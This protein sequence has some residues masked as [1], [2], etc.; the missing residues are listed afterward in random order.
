MILLR[1]LADI[2]LYLTFGLLVYLFF[3]ND[4]TAL[5][6]A[7]GSGIISALLFIYTANI[8]RSRRHRH[9]NPSSIWDWF[10]FID[11]IEIP[12]RLLW[13]LFSNIWR[14]FD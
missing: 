13:W 5:W 4:I 1:L 14:I 12:L 9:S 7:I 6:I 10:D 3:T 8:N 2:L 11:I